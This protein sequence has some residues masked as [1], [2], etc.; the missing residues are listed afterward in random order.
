LDNKG[1]EI[2]ELVEVHRVLGQLRLCLSDL[3]YQ[4]TRPLET[5]NIPPALD[6]FPG[7][8]KITIYGLFPKLSNRRHRFKKGRLDHSEHSSLRRKWF[9]LIKQALAGYPGPPISR[10]I[11]AV[12]YFTPYLC[13][14]DN[15]TVSMIINA[16]TTYKAIGP[17]DT[18]R[19]VNA[20]VQTATQ[21]MD[22][23]RTEIFVLKNRGEINT[24]PHSLLK[25]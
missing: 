9:L 14:I 18:Y 10:A 12:H 16:L 2:A 19:H 5:T 13:D 11:V 25:V 17:D 21:E 15:Y 24:A 23:P 4:K 6:V 20:I 8:L 3:I 1:R 7:G 22:N